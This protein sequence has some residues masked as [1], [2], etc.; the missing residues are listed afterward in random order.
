MRSSNRSFQSVFMYVRVSVSFRVYVFDR[1]LQLSS[2]LFILNVN[3]L[4][5]GLV[6]ALVLQKKK[7]KE[8]SHTDFD[9]V[10]GVAPNTVQLR[11]RENT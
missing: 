1:S 9:R 10:D 6:I 11:K 2:P 4:C 5:V 7:E 3:R 8:T